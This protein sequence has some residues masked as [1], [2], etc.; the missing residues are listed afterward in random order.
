MARVAPWLLPLFLLGLMLSAGLARNL[1]V[2]MAAGG[3]VLA[4]TP[5]YPLDRL[6]RRFMLACAV[7]PVTY[8][9]NMAL[10]GWNARA[11]SVRP[12]CWQPC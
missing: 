1:A 4:V 6:D 3:L 10:L 11:L 5:G 7:L 2:L 8:L 12:T 9:L